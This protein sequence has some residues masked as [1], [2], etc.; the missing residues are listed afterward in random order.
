MRIRSAQ[1]FAG[2]LAAVLLL[3]SV[4]VQANIVVNGGFETGDFT[5]WTQFGDTSFS[6]VFDNSGTTP[7]NPPLVQSGMFAASFGPPTPGGIDQ[8]LPTRPG[9]L[10]TITFGLQNELDLNG[11][12]TPNSFAFNWDGGPPVFSLTN[13]TAFPYRTFSFNLLAPST[14]TD[15]RFTFTQ[16]PAFWDLDN[17]TA[18]VPEPGSLALAGIG[19][20]LAAAFNRR[21]RV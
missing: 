16:S 7:G 19:I 20:A 11:V 14:T 17:V 5:G 4:G 2:G 18:D 6:G 15:L 12:S 10:Y 13:S 21:R 9:K 1:R 8:I 3:A